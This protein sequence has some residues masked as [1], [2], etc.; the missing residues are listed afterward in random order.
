MDAHSR[1]WYLLHK[2]N[3][4][5]RE[6]VASNMLFHCTSCKASFDPSCNEA[7]VAFKGTQDKIFNI[8]AQS[9][10][11]N[12]LLNDIGKRQLYQILQI[13]NPG[14]RCSY[15][16]ERYRLR[17]KLFSFQENAVIRGT[18]GIILLV[19]ILIIIT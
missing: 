11:V 19:V 3:R 5:R 8:I 18:S 2:C 13:F 12:L 17:Y 1:V 4:A 14:K 10:F 15:V 7:I 16:G 6:H 9:D